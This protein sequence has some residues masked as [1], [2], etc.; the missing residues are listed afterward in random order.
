[1]KTMR[2]LFSL[3]LLA[4][5]L[6]CAT[7]E[8]SAYRTIGTITVSVDGTM[9]GWGDF[10]RAGHAEPADEARVKAAYERY[11]SA[12]RLARIAVIT[13][14]TQPDGAS[15]LQTALA[16]TQAASGQLIGLIQTLLQPKGIL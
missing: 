10:V 15:T 14:K 2:Q 4:A 5:L 6:G 8:Q 16:T 9:N 1:M 13:S 3:L 7:P 12:M 11:Q